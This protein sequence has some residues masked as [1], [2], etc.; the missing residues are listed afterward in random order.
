MVDAAVHFFPSTMMMW[1]PNLVFTGGSV[2]TGFPSDDTGNAKAASWNGP[3]MEPRV[4]QPRDPPDLKEGR[5]QF[6]ASNQTTPNV[7]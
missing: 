2:Q 4:I 3:T 1:Y 7:R 5:Q 6:V